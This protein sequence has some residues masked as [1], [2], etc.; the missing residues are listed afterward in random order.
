MT[1]DFEERTAINAND[2]QDD[3]V[4]NPA[5]IC[6]RAAERF[7]WQQMRCNFN[8][9]RCA[10]WA[11]TCASI[12]DQSAALLFVLSP[13]KREA[14]LGA[15]LRVPTCARCAGE[16]GITVRSTR[17]MNN[18]RISELHE[19]F[20]KQH[21]CCCCRRSRSALG[22]INEPKKRYLSDCK[23]MRKS[24]ETWETISGATVERVAWAT[25]KR[26]VTGDFFA[27]RRQP[28]HLERMFVESWNLAR[29]AESRRVCVTKCKYEKKNEDLTAVCCSLTPTVSKIKR[30]NVKQNWEGAPFE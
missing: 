24:L 20:P 11:K 2:H 22:Q 9:I 30:I 27:Q 26:K 6:D 19:N 8:D 21:C 23:S 17:T 10:V 16:A 7:F 14:R 1:R 4:T 15:F 13:K 5:Q 18:A 12:I 3:G 28:F 29:C 25:N